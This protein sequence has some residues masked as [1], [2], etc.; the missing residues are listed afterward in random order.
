[1]RERPPPPN[2]RHRVLHLKVLKVDKVDI[3]SRVVRA[4]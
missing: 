1:M 4:G 2:H 3:L